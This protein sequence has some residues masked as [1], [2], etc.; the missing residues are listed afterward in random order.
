MKFIFRNLTLFVLLILSLHGS[1]ISEL[2]KK[3]HSGNPEGQFQL[4]KAFDAGR[5]VQ[6][7]ALKAAEWYYRS[8]IQGHADAAEFL[9]TL[10]EE[11]SGVERDTFIAKEWKGIAKRNRS[12]QKLKSS[13]YPSIDEWQDVPEIQVPPSKVREDVG[14]IGQIDA[15]I[16]ELEKLKK[17]L[18]KRNDPDNEEV[19]KPISFVD[20]SK[21]QIE[22]RSKDPPKK[23]RKIPVPVKLIK[24]PS[25]KQNFEMGVSYFNGVGLEQN[26]EQAHKYFKLSAEKGYEKA[27]HKLGLIYFMG[28]GFAQDYKISYALF[29]L[30]SRYSDNSSSQALNVLSSTMTDSQITEAR[31]IAESFHRRISR[32]EGL[33]DLESEKEINIKKDLAYRLW[34]NRVT[35]TFK[36]SRKP[37]IGARF[38]NPNDREKIYSYTTFLLRD[39]SS[40]FL[41]LLPEEPPFSP[42]FGKKSFLLKE[43]WGE[44]KSS[45]LLNPIE[46]QEIAF[47]YDPRLIFVPL[48]INPDEIK[49]IEFFQLASSTD[50]LGQVNIFSNTDGLFLKGAFTK[51]GYNYYIKFFRQQT[52]AK[53]TITPT[54]GNYAFSFDGELVGVMM[55]KN[56]AYYVKDLVQNLYPAPKTRIGPSFE[57]DK[58][59][60]LLEN[61]RVKYEQID[62]DYK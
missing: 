18:L 35:V 56:Y 62:D 11:G 4:A 33:G 34:E 36:I 50:P 45:K 14:N 6:A 15:K 49:T 39:R 22:K 1:D 51:T 52:K 31:K 17:E 9:A 26:Y 46:L 58:F 20:P 61:M 53:M 54:I 13:E 28:Y 5:G 10:Y 43:I 41:I 48:S 29:L 8:A 2:L 38:E 16:A 47:V 42:I 24:L 25:P 23:I 59:H 27:L 7:D 57:E 12:D 40:A 37:T 60:E 21:N 44:V 55:N 32:G 3:A 30:G 19:K